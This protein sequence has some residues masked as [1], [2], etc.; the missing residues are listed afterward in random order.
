LDLNFYPVKIHGILDKTKLSHQKQIIL[1]STVILF[2]SY[3]LN[4]LIT[5]DDSNLTV[6][7]TLVL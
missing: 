7:F 6:N 1:G 3:I 4:M 2:E 5:E